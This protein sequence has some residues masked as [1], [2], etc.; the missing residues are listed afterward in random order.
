LSKEYD[1]LLIA[2]SIGIT[3][4][5]A[6]GNTFFEIN[7]GPTNIPNAVKITNVTDESF[8]VTYSTDDDVVGTLNYGLEPISLDNLV[9]DDR[10]QLSQK[11]TKR[12]S[13]SITLKGLQPQ[14]TYYFSITSDDEVFLNNESPYNAKTGSIISKTPTTQ[15]PITG[16]VLLPD[17]STPDE[18]LIYVMIAGAQFLSTTLKKDGTYTIPLNTIRNS[19]FNDFFELSNNTI[20][21]LDII[22]G[23]FITKIDVSLDQISPVPTISLS[24]NYD[25]SKNETKNIGNNSTTSSELFPTFGV[26]QEIIE[27]EILTPKADEELKNQPTFIGTAQPN[28]VVKI[29][30]H[31]DE[32][33]STNVNA[34]ANGEWSYTPPNS[35][36]PGEHTI[37]ITT[38]NSLGITKRVTK[39]FNVP[40]AQSQTISI[41]PKLSPSI[42][43]PTT[44]PSPN[45]INTTIVTPNPTVLPENTNA[46]KTQAS[47]SPTPTDKSTR[48]SSV[49][50][51][52]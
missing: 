23:K 47:I 5:L 18:G 46:L 49:L 27:P 44:T 35:M 32:N 12:N 26:K 25:F 14:T 20:L 7:A 42:I 17:G 10:D 2:V 51:V 38:I 34:D 13:H 3:T 24:G 15:I 28:Q 16:K 50:F 9:L 48:N 31:S 19:S 39:T 21:N 37:T 36:S 30:I 52:A 22:S 43:N 6:G 33:I 40:E 29:E 4:F 8:T 1:V 11:V 45:L 41:S